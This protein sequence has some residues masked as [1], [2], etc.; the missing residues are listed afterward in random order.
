MVTNKAPRDHAA[1]QTEIAAIKPGHLPNVLRVIA[2]LDGVNAAINVAKEL[3][4]ARLWVPNGGWGNDALITKIVSPLAAEALRN[5]IGGG[6]TIIVPTARAVINWS[7]VTSL[8][9][10]G[11]SYNEIAA[12]TKLSNRQI[13]R[14]CGGIKPK[15]IGGNHG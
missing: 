1:F 2:E 3:G 13:L 15:D 5:E 14:I 10:A 12:A 6:V 4:G 9:M 7:R 11:K 8:R